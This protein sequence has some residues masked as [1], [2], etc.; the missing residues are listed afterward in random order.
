M[1]DFVYGAYLSA[2]WNTWNLYAYYGITPIYNSPPLSDSSQRVKMNALN[3]G[4]I[5]YIL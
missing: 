1:N 5:F 2:G 3:V 4:I